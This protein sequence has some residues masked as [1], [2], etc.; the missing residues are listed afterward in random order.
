MKL[1]PFLILLASAASLQARPVSFAPANSVLGQAGFGGETVFNPPTASSLNAPEGLAI[2]PTSGKLFVADSENH[3]ILRFS[4]ADAYRTNAVAE[5][6][7][8]QPDFESNEPNRG[9]MNPAVNSLDFPTALA[10]DGQGRLWAADSGNRRVLRFD[11]ASIKPK[12]G[13][14]ADGVLGQAGFAAKGGFPD[15]DVDSPQ[16]AVFSDPMGVA[17]DGAGRLWVS[18]SGL[19]RV[20]RFDSPASLG[21]SFDGDADGYLGRFE[22][23]DFVADAGASAFGGAVSG[24][25]VSPDGTLWVADA[26]NNRVL[27]FDDAA[28]KPDG[29]DA[30]GVLGQ[31][32]FDA[33][34]FEETSATSLSQPYY[35]TAA[36]NGT[37]WI[38]DY[39]NNRVVGHLNAASKANGAAAN[40]V[41]GQPNFVSSST[42]I[43]ANRATPSPTQVA[44]GFQG[45]LFVGQYDEAGRVRRWSD[46]VSIF[47]RRVV[48]ANR[49]GVAV[50]RGRAAGATLVQFRVPRQGGFR[51]VRGSAAVWNAR[52]ARLASR[53][54]PVR[55]RAVAFD[56]RSVQTVVRIRRPMPRRRR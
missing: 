6:V 17:V 12:F 41:L 22:D 48:R 24:L 19:S 27:R 49:A 30:D 13:A 29:A 35:V 10:I 46:P 45:S 21:T 40:I 5:A 47:A 8:G 50:V 33:F 53:V 2:D 3:R 7:F 34:D 16:R 56:G 37:L 36:P 39:N 42:G 31:P 1:L 18:D 54:T 25:S 11:N 26:S 51:R 38:S 20:L 9:E 55:F 43:P 52:V 14:T 32:D 4:S 44:V 28:N 15:F 23:G